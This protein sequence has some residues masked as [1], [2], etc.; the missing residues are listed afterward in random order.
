MEL[1]GAVAIVT[2]SGGAIGRAISRE[3][4]RQGASVVCAS[5]ED[6]GLGETVQ[7]IK[8]DGGHALA[9]PTDVTQPDQVERMTAKTVEQFGKLDIL[10]NNAGI[11][12]AIG[13]LWEVDPQA[14][15]TD[16]TTN[17][18]GAFLCIHTVLP[19]MMQHNCGVVINMAG[20][21]YDRPNIGGTGY[22]ASKAGLMRLTDTLAAELGTRH[23]I[24]VYGFWPGFVRSVMTHMLADTPQGQ[25]WLPHVAQG[26]LAH[27][28]HPAEDV[29]RAMASLITISRPALSGRIFSYDDDFI[30]VEQHA[31][32]IQRQDLRQ[33]RVHKE[34]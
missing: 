18:F 14:W 23:N 17:L 29:G 13:G 5:L 12:R 25:R 19:H 16:V 6:A 3:F 28:D 11:F 4:A 15:W 9:L 32:E 24:Q 7:L 30:Q 34:P 20:G 2:G 26:L 31:D 27:E 8:A 1:K 21:G 33:L 22:A 10:V